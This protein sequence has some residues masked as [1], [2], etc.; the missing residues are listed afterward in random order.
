METV[1]GGGS[2]LE[3]ALMWLRVAAGGLAPVAALWPDL[4]R[5]P[6]ATDPDGNAP[7]AENLAEHLPDAAVFSPPCVQ[8]AGVVSE[9]D[10]LVGVV[11]AAPGSGQV[12]V[13]SATPITPADRLAATQPPVPRITLPRVRAPPEKPPSLSVIVVIVVVV[14]K[15]SLLLF[16]S[17]LT[18]EAVARGKATTVPLV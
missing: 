8:A 12:S 17:R 2:S 16:N 11:S 7:L 9:A 4:K 13:A 3:A 1:P 18:V 10:V 6:V 14:V 5:R 15:I